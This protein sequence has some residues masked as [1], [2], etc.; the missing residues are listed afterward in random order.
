[1]SRSEVETFEPVNHPRGDPSCSLCASRSFH[2]LRF[3]FSFVPCFD[4]H[5]QPVSSSTFLAP[6][7]LLLAYEY[8]QM[9]PVS[10]DFRLSYPARFTARPSS[11]LQPVPSTNAFD[12]SSETSAQVFCSRVLCFAT[13]MALKVALDHGFFAPRNSP[14]RR[15]SLNATRPRIPPLEIIIFISPR[16]SFVRINGLFLRATPSV[17]FGRRFL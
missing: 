16:H 10:R 6:F 1:M 5:E 13:T 3:P 7:F 11:S 14:V 4:S 8:T 12:I 2:F 9:S 17:T 15:G